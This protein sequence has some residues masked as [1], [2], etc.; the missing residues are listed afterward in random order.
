[1]SNSPSLKVFSLLANQPWDRNKI[2]FTGS[3]SQFEAIFIGFF[4]S[5]VITRQNT[6]LTTS[7]VAVFYK[8]GQLA[9]KM[10]SAKDIVQQWLASFTFMNMGILLTV[11]ETHTAL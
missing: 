5:H 2:Y 10:P 11:T 3:S 8:G 1:V 6:D 9:L 4:T 7:F